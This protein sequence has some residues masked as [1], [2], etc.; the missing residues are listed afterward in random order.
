MNKLKIFLSRSQARVLCKYDLLNDKRNKIVKHPDGRN[1]W[2][3]RKELVYPDG[4][5][6]GMVYLSNRGTYVY[7]R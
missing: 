6:L 4:K 7:H 2:V 5:N 1:L 3:L